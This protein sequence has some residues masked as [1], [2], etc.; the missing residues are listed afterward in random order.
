[1]LAD[2]INRR[3]APMLRSGYSDAVGRQLLAT[4]AALAGQVA[5]M[6]HDAGQHGLAERQFV[7][8]LRLAKAAGDRMYGAHLLANLSTQ[9]VFLGHAKPAVRLATAA[10]DGAG[11]APAAVMARLYTAEACAHAVAG[12]RVS[13]MS[14]LRR[15]ETAVARTTVGS[16]PAWVGYFTPAHFAGTAVRC[17]RDL[18]LYRQA[19]RH[20]DSA[21]DLDFRKRSNTGTAHRID[22]HSARSRRRS[23]RR[24]RVRAA[25]AR[26][27][28]RREVP[29]S[30]RPN[31]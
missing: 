13:C 5:F 23:R 19:L 1:L 28:R 18:G 9:A 31:H 26:A 6:V 25:R 4:A 30:R 20:A 8:A 16:G 29:S 7:I 12:D 10:V 24:G 15:A 27:D 22:R 14:A 21:L 11:R 2:F 3:V 17:Y